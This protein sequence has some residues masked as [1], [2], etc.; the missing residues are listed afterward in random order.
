MPREFLKD[1]FTHGFGTADASPIQRL[2]TKNQRIHLKLGKFRQ[3]T[4]LRTGTLR[5]NQR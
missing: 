2:R 4:T 1:V 5:E 3:R